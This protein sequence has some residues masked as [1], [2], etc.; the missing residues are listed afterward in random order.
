[1]SHATLER[2]LISSGT[3]V[4]IGVALGVTALMSWS[5]ADFGPLSVVR[6]MRLVIPSGTLIMVGLHII[7]SSLFAVG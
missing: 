6:T 2:C 1:L 5:N 4:L 3:L 7:G